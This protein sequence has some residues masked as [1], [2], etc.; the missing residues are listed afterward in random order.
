MCLACEEAEIWYRSRLLEQI[1][2]GEMPADLTADDL[3]AMELPLPG[4]VS[5]VEQP[6]GTFSIIKTAAAAGGFHC[7][8]PDG[9]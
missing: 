8:S 7:D 2:R 3:R 6:D 4:E 9:P 1:A 5:L